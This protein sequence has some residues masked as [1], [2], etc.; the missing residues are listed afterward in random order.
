M[1]SRKGVP[2]LRV[3]MVQSNQELYA[4]LLYSIVSSDSAGGQ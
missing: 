2:I 4:W 3:I 1:V